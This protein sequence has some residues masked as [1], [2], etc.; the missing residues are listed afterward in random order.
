[1]TICSGMRPLSKIRIH[2]KHYN[3]LWL[4]GIQCPFD[5]RNTVDIYAA[6]QIIS[7]CSLQCFTLINL[8]SN[9]FVGCRV[10]FG[11]HI[12]CD[13]IT[14]G[15]F[16]LLG[17]FDAKLFEFWC[18]QFHLF[19]RLTVAWRDLRYFGKVRYAVL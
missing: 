9:N 18:N 16:S 5:T 15:S 10:G 11:I 7:A 17:F 19:F 12:L 4:V 8:Q 1:M 3:Q 13:D 6:W 14:S 2:D